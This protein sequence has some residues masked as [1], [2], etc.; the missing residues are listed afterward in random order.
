MRG[1]LSPTPM[2]HPKPSA[3]PSLFP[4]TR[5]SL[6]IHARDARSSAEALSELCRLYWFP[7]YAYARHR[8]YDSAD[9]EDLTQGLFSKLLSNRGFEEQVTPRQGRLRSWLLASMNRFIV[10]EWRKRT[11]EKRGG[12]VEI[13]S[14][15][16]DVAENRYARVPVSKGTPE[17][18]FDYQWALTVLGRTFERLREEY[19]LSGKGEI[20]A[21]LRPVL[22][23]SPKSVKVGEIA[24]TLGVTENH[25]RV[26]AFRLR[27]H[28]KALLRE[29]L[30]E[31]VGSEHDLEKEMADF[32]MILSKGPAGLT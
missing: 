31:T 6:V 5:W 23:G 4:Q 28:F 3:K 8:G 20:Y 32:R 12:D 30:L 24:A 27:K 18:T 21:S 16:S 17:D 15:E 25:A 29:E 14:I 13:V 1:T 7:L 10:S 9:A 11:A 22:D 19:E 26:L 2:Q